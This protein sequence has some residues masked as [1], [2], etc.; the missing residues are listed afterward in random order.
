MIVDNFFGLAIGLAGV[1]GSWRLGLVVLHLVL[2]LL[3]AFAGGGAK[4]DLAF[5]VGGENKA[6]SSSWI[7]NKW[8]KV[9]V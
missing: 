5:G 1:F 3:L 2:A 4:R 9:N 7:L 6:N 8:S